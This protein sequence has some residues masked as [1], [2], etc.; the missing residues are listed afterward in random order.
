M[1]EERLVVDGEERE[2]LHGEPEEL[3]EE[4]GWEE[5]RREE[6]ERV[7]GGVEVVLLHRS[8]G[9]RMIAMK[10]VNCFTCICR[11]G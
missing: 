4:L 3:H 1:V 5:R 6:E 10:K 7:E 11:S 2:E 9:K 8:G